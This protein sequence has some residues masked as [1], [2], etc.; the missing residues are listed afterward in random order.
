[1]TRQFARLTRLVL[2]GVNLALLVTGGGCKAQPAKDAGFVDGASMSK[3]PALPF[4]RVWFKSGFD[5]A[6]YTK[7]HVAPVNTSYMLKMTD[8]Q[9]GERK[10]DIEKDLARLATYSQEAI[11]KA[12][13]DDPRH[14]F[15]V[16]DAPAGDPKTLVLEMALTEVVP[17]KVALNALGYAPF[18][19]GLGIT[20]MRTVAKDVSSVAMEA[21]VH[22]ADSGEIVAMFADREQQQLAPVSVRGWT[23]YSHA[24]TIIRQWATQ[25]VQV[26]TRK[27]GEKVKDT[28]PFTLQPW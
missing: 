25:F 6:S 26:A 21:R 2:L 15:E 14:R 9:K 5:F 23:W 3:D 18:F 4:N 24:E 13:R 19:I 8:W 27:P 28:D 7:L 11:K 16:V 12:F 10:E 22:A 1:M 20:A 17:S